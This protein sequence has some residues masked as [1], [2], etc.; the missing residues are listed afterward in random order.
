MANYDRGKGVMQEREYGSYTLRF[1]AY[2]FDQ[3]LLWFI[4]LSLFFV[5]VS[6]SDSTVK[7]G[8][9]T[10]WVIW[11]LIFF[12]WI[13][14]WGYLILTFILFK[15][16]FGKMFAGLTIEKENEGKPTLADALI[17]FPVG[18]TVSS[19]LCGLGYLW[20]IK[21]PKKKGFH[22]HFAGT[23]VVKSGPSWPLMIFLPIL[24]L[25]VGLIIILIVSSGVESGLWA[26]VG[27]DIGNFIQTVGDFLKNNSTGQGK[28]VI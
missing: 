2:L 1:F 28:T 14:S 13:I 9:G 20:I 4:P 16:S 22:D 8:T 25:V 17:R 3:L 24:I 12:Q 11:E 23:V 15:A 5:V 7:F 18:Y 27:N 6:A 19:L 10:L 21:D 26:A